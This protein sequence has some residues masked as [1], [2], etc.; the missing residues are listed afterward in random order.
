MRDSVAPTLT[1]DT[2]AQCR[3]ILASTEVIRRPERNINLKLLVLCHD[4]TK[5]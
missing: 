5:S 1:V 2:K 4:R 3:I